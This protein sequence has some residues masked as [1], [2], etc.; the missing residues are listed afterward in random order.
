MGSPPLP[1]S[2]GHNGRKVREWGSHGA[3][4]K[5]YAMS[6]RPQHA[7]HA[8]G[9]GGVVLLQPPSR[10]ASQRNGRRSMVS[11][12]AG[13]GVAAVAAAGRE[14]LRRLGASAG[15]LV[16]RRGG[17]SIR[18]GGGGAAPRRLVGTASLPREGVPGSG[19]RPRSHGHTHMG[20]G[21]TASS[22]PPPPPSQGLADI[23]GDS[24]RLTAA[25]A[26]TSA[27]G[28]G[29]D[30][31]PPPLADIFSA[32]SSR[33]PPGSPPLPPHRTGEGG[34]RWD[35]QRDGGSTRLGPPFTL[36]SFAP[37]GGRG[38]VAGA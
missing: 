8:R 16:G 15:S 27:A 11:A 5:P 35:R 13:W 20:A 28:E 38:G 21:S 4:C 2:G 9:T 22:P 18:V 34:G 19:R 30:P 26:G 33:A 36:P 7:S 31:P 3:P 10:G 1:S 37:T 25:R 29:I 14:A 32:I 17:R 6:T 12:G 23:F 24:R